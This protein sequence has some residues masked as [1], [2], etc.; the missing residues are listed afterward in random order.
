VK[1]P[2]FWFCKDPQC[3]KH[4]CPDPLFC[5]QMEHTLQLGFRA[6]RNAR[7]GRRN[8]KADSANKSEGQSNVTATQNTKA[9]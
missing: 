8:Q 3:T 1:L 9:P 4:L 5:T 7:N 6:E 2:E